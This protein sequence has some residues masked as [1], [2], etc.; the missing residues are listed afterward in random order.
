MS[1]CRKVTDIYI[2]I[3]LSVFPLFT[4]FIGYAGITDAKF[5]FFSA[6]TILWF[7]AIIF[8]CIQDRV[9]LQALKPN[10]PT[11]KLILVYGALCC[12]SAFCSPYFPETLLGAGRWDGLVTLLLYLLIF[13]GVQTFG[14]LRAAHLYAM[15]SALLICTVI[16]FLQLIGLDPLDLF[17]RDLTYYD[18]NIHYS[19]EFLG[20]IGNVDLLA[21][22]LCLSVPL[23]SVAYI[24][25]KRHRPLLI[26]AAA[27]MFLLLVSRVA[28]GLVGILACVVFSAPVLLINRERPVRAM[29]AIAALSLAAFLAFAL[30]FSPGRIQFICGA[31]AYCALATSIVTMLLSILLRRCKRLPE[32]TP[33]TYTRTFLF[34]VLIAVIVSVCVIYFWSGTSGTI[35]EISRILHGEIQDSFGSSRIRIWRETLALVPERPILGG[36]PGSIAKRL[37]IEFS[38]YVAETDSVRKTFVDN[39]HNAYLTVLTDTG[40]PGLLLY[41]S[42]ILLCFLHW[43]RHRADKSFTPALGSAV[44]CYWVMDF[45]GLGLCLIAPMFWLLWGLLNVKT[46]SSPDAPEESSS[47]KNTE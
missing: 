6:A 16:A 29:H 14:E 27:G 47:P 1:A 25:D 18:A 41:L 35:Y 23:F 46:A 44:L 34:L 26:P 7:A 33:E 5:F 36:G 13:I 40:I 3:M 24:T 4:G 17:P 45:F 10:T 30:H 19:G 21:G 43:V 28:G 12:I 11:S 37:Q 42:M 38:R 2:F 15:S 20:T 39:A 9:A 32:L 22:F 31:A 8:F